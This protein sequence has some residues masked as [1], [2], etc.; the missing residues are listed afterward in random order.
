MC[1]QLQ[2][3]RTGPPEMHRR[4]HQGTTSASCIRYFTCIYISY[5]EYRSLNYV[6]LLMADYLS[7]QSGLWESSN[8]TKSAYCQF[9]ALPTVRP[10]RAF[11]ARPHSPAQQLASIPVTSVV[12]ALPKLRVVA[13][14]RPAAVVRPRL[15][16]LRRR[17]AP[18]L[19]AHS[20]PLSATRLASHPRPLQLTKRTMSAALGCPGTWP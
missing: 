17:V 3:P 8:N 10:L 20:G 9:L 19:Q 2:Q 4:L 11:G 16:V 7:L 13:V 1:R 14:H 5:I 12:L 15:R 18:L 6:Y